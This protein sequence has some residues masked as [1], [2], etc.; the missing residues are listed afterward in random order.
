MV[1]PQCY[2]YNKICLDLSDVGEIRS[3]YET[4]TWVLGMG[5][6]EYMDDSP[7]NYIKSPLILLLD[8]SSVYKRKLILKVHLFRPT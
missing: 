5:I 1:L 2:I 6:S 3:L 4:H 7:L 8:I